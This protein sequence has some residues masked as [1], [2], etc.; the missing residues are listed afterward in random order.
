MNQN[1]RLVS[2]E[3]FKR[4]S[5]ICK[6]ELDVVSRDENNSYEGTGKLSFLRI[7]GVSEFWKSRPDSNIN[8]LVRNIL[9]S[10]DRYNIPFVYSVVGNEYGIEI[11]YGTAES[12]IS[13]LKSSI[14]A[15]FPG[16][17]IEICQ[18]NPLRFA[19][20][21]FG[22]I[23]TGIPSQLSSSCAP[24]LREVDSQ[25]NQIENICRAMMGRRFI[26]LV[27]A[28]GISPILTSLA[29]QRLL[30]ELGE[31]HEMIRKT[32]SGGAQGN[33]NVESF[34]YA[35]QEYFNNL[36]LL[37]E[38]IKT[39][40]TNGLW[41]ATSYYA[42]DDRNTADELAGVI[43]S[44]FSGVDSVPEKLRVTPLPSVSEAIQNCYLLS[45][46]FTMGHNHPLGSWKPSEGQ[47]SVSLFSY[48]YQTIL[49]SDQL[50]ILS[51]IP[52]TEMPGFYVD[53]YVEFDTAKRQKKSE[54]E[55]VI[56]GDIT[57]SGNK[58]WE[59]LTNEY[60]INL[61]DLTRH[62][63]IVGVTGGGKT[64]TSKSILSSLWNDKRIPFLVIESAKREYWELRKIRGYEDLTVFTLGSEERGNSVKY[65]INPFECASGTSLLTHIDYLLATFKAAF[66]LYPPMPYALETAVFEV[67]TDKGWDITENKNKYGRT[68]FPTLSDLYN[69]IDVVV[70]RMG[71]DRE[72][73]SNVKAALKARIH[74][75]MIGG[76][77][78]MLDTPRSVPLQEL[79][80]GPVVM[81]LEDLGDDD[82]KS[83]VM[84]ILMVQL[85]EYRKS[86]MNSGSKNLQHVLLIEEAHRLL[87]NVPE[88]SE[89]SNTRA[90]S[91]EFFCNM[92][93]EIRTYG[94]GIIIADQIPTK[95]ATDTIK[96]T[97]LKI[98]HRIVAGDDRNVIGNS[99]NM[100][101]EQIQYLSTLDRGYA[102]V[103]SEGDNKPKN[104]KF[105]L[106][107]NDYAI[108]R[109]EVLAASTSRTVAIVP[110]YDK[111]IDYHSG[112][113]FCESQ[114]I[115]KD[116]VDELIKQNISI[117]D[118]KRLADEHKCSIDVVNGILNVKVIKAWCGDN[119]DK[120]I[121]VAG[122]ALAQSQS[123]SEGKKQNVIS[124]YIKSVF[125]EIEE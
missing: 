73:Q 13:V 90:K 2:L 20:C 8:N 49:N 96:N 33:I 71:Y 80:N 19:A 45:N 98:V 92:L 85:Y 104:V 75:L 50:S 58:H 27:I 62:A 112:C 86:Q 18:Q 125:D 29:H 36:S 11:L 54:E 25:N 21:T 56:L 99:M 23:V 74:S 47:N 46:L 30:I 69:K 87:K 59:R 101:E 110:G 83:F 65:R 64:N 17:E 79:L 41:R 113:T 55:R 77:G 118:L 123:V 68:A 39:G 63:L 102:A 105:P 38:Q 93:A 67:Y 78:A 82:T 97:N 57:D 94:Q 106:I 35:V 61:N 91:I 5:A 48:K 122:H 7:K 76:K 60:S 43:K 26:F 4:N 52:T 108:S 121:C 12:L 22:G 72:V 32:T 53:D 120:K 31:T 81:E 14:E 70:D 100:S 111:V 3:Y 66:E 51:S 84:G 37:Q 15:L 95:L 9:N 28:K 109:K 116:Q 88:T 6:D 10:L 40:N 16:V 119:I 103:Y 124:N 44:V 89:G 107:K 24:T 34:N 42:S 117:C 114:C 1:D 115:Y